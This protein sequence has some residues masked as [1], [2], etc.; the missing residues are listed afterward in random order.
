MK[1]IGII[2]IARGI[3]K[4]KLSYFSAEDMP[5]GS[6]VSVSLRSKDIPGLVVSS[7]DVLEEKA[8]IKNYSF[9]V[10]KINKKK[11]LEIFQ[12]QF[13][14][15]CQET[16]RYLAATTGSVLYS[17]APSGILENLDKVESVITPAK[18]RPEPGEKFVIQGDDE[19]RYV[20]YKS[21][22]REEFAKGYSVV[23][24][25]PTIQEI[26]KAQE[27]LSKGIEPYTFILHSGLTKKEIVTEWNKILAE[28]HTVLILATGSFLSI[29]RPDIGTI[30]V[31][32]ESSRTYK[33][34]VRPYVDTRTFAEQLAKNLGAR[35]IFG[36][37]FLRVE[38]LWRFKNNELYELFPLK[39]R[40]LTTSSQKVVDMRTGQEI[41]NYEKLGKDGKR[42]IG[43]KIKFKVLSTDLENLIRSNQ[44]DS[45]NLFI[46]ASRR[47]LSPSTVCGDCGTIVTCHHCKAPVV[48]HLANKGNFFLCH[49]C[50]ER[51][52]AMEQCSKCNSW[53]LTTLGIGSEFV[54]QEIQKLF[55]DI[56]I[57]RMDSDTVN[58][59]KKALQMAEKFHAAPGS[60]MIGTEMAISYITEKI[61]NSAVVSMDSFFA[62]PD[63]RI[64]ERIINIIL[65]IKAI[66][67]RNFILQTRQ[68]D[69]KVW[70]YS[71]RGNLADF[72][73]DEIS[74]RKL[75]DYPPFTTLIKISLTG[76]RDFVISEM[77]KL[78][79][80]IEPHNIDVFPAFIPG[81]AGKYIMHGL[82]KIK[83]GEWIDETLLAKLQIL[84]LS[85]SVNVDPES[86]L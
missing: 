8:N 76:D 40:S 78:Q 27:S 84:P 6:I 86:L 15:T 82:I 72:Y 80:I 65:K 42:E 70:D 45:E 64:N 52:T 1:L 69:E 9:T 47:G 26:K 5:I 17:V 44:E 68:P 61:Q 35:I 14:N 2:P 32:R 22:I 4:E 49:R 20:N 67:T 55:P 62:L 57:F 33:S 53:R 3:G 43:E 10:K 30:I 39:F 23:F 13:V 83:R 77:E 50:G 34:Q 48:L 7:V 60:V 75:L 21:I 19:E 16:A 38:T 28:K 25:L 74:D 79:K 24:I 54:E 56:K 71:L 58:T 73:R 12:P 85:Y 36:D 66:T 31:D 59:H 46:F 63:F 18:I 51:R 41:I 81:L 29:P 11:P 37:I